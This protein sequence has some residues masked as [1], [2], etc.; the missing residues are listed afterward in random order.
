MCGIGMNY[1]I[2]SVD[3]SQASKINKILKDDLISR[4]S[5]FIRDAQALSIDKDVRYVLIEGSDEAIK[6]AEELFK[7]AGKKEDEAEAK[8]IYN[9][10]KNEESDVAQGVG[11]IFGD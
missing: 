2:F 8:S 4:Q 3:K 5:I 11:L 1:A 7:D 10:I 9:K 6:K